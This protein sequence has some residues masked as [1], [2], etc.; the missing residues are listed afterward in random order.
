MKIDTPTARGKLTARREPY[1]DSMGT[2]KAI[3]Y[4]AGPG[5]WIARWR[6]P[7]G[8]KQ[9]HSLDRKR[10]EG[11]TGKEVYDAACNLAREWFKQCE[12]GGN[13]TVTVS[14]GCEEY[15]VDLLTRKGDKA[16]R[17]AKDRYTTHIEKSLGKRRVDQLS[18]H[19]VEK[20]HKGMAKITGTED[21]IRA[22]KNSANRTLTVLKAA[23][24]Y[25]ARI[26][27]IIDRTAWG[28]VKPFKDVAGV[29]DVYLTRP[30][31]KRLLGV[32]EGALHDLIDAGRLTGAR[33]SELTT[34]EAGAF[35]R[36]RGILTVTGK[37]GTRDM[38]L[39]RDAQTFFKEQAKGK[40]PKA[41]LFP[42]DDG[43]PWDRHF[44][45]KRFREAVKK[46]KL[47]AGTVF[48]SLRHWYISEA[49]KAGVDIELL[50]K[51]VGNSAQIIRKHYHKFIKDDVLNEIDKLGAL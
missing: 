18:L 41:P 31:L 51:N 20:W 36:K 4:R 1:W 3:G 11:Y 15:L 8:K 30:Q 19:E 49:L 16:K 26:H 9:Y 5:A 21:E 48:Y 50:A 42:R 43:T 33:L 34:A 46:T 14:E 24:N 2:C 27:R 12:G 37:T 35:D 28:D 39:S 40:L 32:T 29:R 22:S 44:L 6:T 23:L 38:V 25:T 10:L 17:T 7:E 45:S 13:V 47:P